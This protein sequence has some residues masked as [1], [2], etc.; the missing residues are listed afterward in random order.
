MEASE[1]SSNDVALDSALLTELDRKCAYDVT[2][3]RFG[4]NIVTLET[5]QYVP[6]LLLLTYIAVNK[7]QYAVLPWKCKKMC[8]HGNVVGMQNISRSC[9]RH[10]RTCVL[11]QS[12]GYFCSILTEYGVCRLTLV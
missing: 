10:E 6:F 7:K 5:Q 12:G 1:V 3:W 4:I 8:S 11:M 9:Q 2:L